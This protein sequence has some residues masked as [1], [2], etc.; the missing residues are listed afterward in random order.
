MTQTEIKNLNIAM[1]SINLQELIEIWIETMH[2]TDHV[3]VVWDALK[4]LEL[5]QERGI[6]V[7]EVEIYDNKILTISTFSLDDALII[8]KALP[9]EQGPY[10]QVFSLGRLITDN[11]DK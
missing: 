8:L 7:D 5:L 4:H 1:Y 3:A 2:P 11:I 6:G 9:I 10:V